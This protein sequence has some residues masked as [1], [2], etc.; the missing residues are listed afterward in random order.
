MHSRFHELV[1]AEIRSGFDPDLVRP[2]EEEMQKVDTKLRNCK[3]VNA[4]QTLQI[5]DL[6]LVC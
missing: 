2:D 5:P 6:V 4:N 3:V 1:P